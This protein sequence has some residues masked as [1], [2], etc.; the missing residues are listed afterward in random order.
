MAHAPLSPGLGQE[1][2]LLQIV[3]ELL[4]AYMLAYPG[5]VRLEGPQV[6]LPVL[7]AAN[8]RLALRELASNAARFGAFASSQGTLAIRWQVTLN[9]SRRL[10]MM[11]AEDGLSEVTFPETIG[12]GTRIIAGVVENYDRVFEA[13]AMR[14]TFELAL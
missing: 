6:A 4:G 13:R 12:R 8:L 7:G 1:A 2:D 14:C 5:R 3:E 9:G 11:W 10:R